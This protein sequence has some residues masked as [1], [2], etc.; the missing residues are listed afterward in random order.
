MK[1][2]IKTNTFYLPFKRGAAFLVL[3]CFLFQTCL[4]FQENKSILSK[5]QVGEPLFSNYKLQTT[6]RS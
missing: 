4:S 6:F 3:I 5:Q 1:S 2:Q